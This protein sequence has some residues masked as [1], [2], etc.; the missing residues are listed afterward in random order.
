METT[1]DIKKMHRDFISSQESYH[2]KL[3]SFNDPEEMYL[4]YKHRLDIIGQLLDLCDDF[5]KGSRHILEAFGE[6]WEHERKSGIPLDTNI[7]FDII[8]PMM[9]LVG[10]KENL[11][12]WSD[13]LY[14]KVKY[15]EEK[16]VIEMTIE[17]I[18][19]LPG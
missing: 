11:Y 10:E 7:L 14:N 16:E 17:D 15:L 12:I 1:I 5:V 8:R 6:Y 2:D 19:K 3:K 4:Q 9:V 13:E 18:D